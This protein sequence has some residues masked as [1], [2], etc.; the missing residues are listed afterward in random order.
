MELVVKNPPTNVGDVRDAGLIPGWGGSCGRGHSILLQYS[1]LENTMDRRARQSIVHGVAKSDT[2]E[3][4]Y[5][6]CKQE[7]L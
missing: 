4:I 3:A 2:T 6:A 1:C 5:H 7:V